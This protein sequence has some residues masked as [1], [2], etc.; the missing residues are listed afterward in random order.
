MSG[1]DEFDLEPRHDR[2]RTVVADGLQQRQRT[3]GVARRVE[4]KRGRVLRVVVAVGVAS[5]FFLDVRGVGEHQRAEVAGACRAEHAA[6]ESLGDQAGQVAAVVEM[7]VGQDD[8]VDVVRVDGER[9]PVAEAEFLESLEEPAVDEH[10][11]T[12]EIEQVFRPGDRPGSSKKCQRRHG[13]TIARDLAGPK[14]RP[15]APEGL[16][17]RGRLT[18][19]PRPTGRRARPSG[20]SGSC[21]IFTV[22][23]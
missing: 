11:V 6:L 19:E 9:L 15:G 18:A 5:V 4:R 2:N 16:R 3:L 22:Y 1:V 12:A 17:T 21:A 20:L 8:G 13:Q 10:A 7:R 23:N 14:G